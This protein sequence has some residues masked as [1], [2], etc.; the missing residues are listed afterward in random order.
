MVFQDPESLYGRLT[1]GDAG[2]IAEVGDLL[3]DAMRSIKASTSTIET[4]AGVAGSGWHG[5]AADAFA[6]RATRLGGV[7]TLAH[8]RLGVIAD[9]LTGAADAYRQLVD[10][11]DAAI[12][13]W[14]ASAPTDE[15]ARQQLAADVNRSMDRARADYEAKLTGVASA[16]GDG[17][18]DG[19]KIPHVGLGSPW[20]PQGMAY[21]KDKDQLLAAYYNGD[22]DL[23]EGESKSRLSMI[24]QTTGDEDKYVDL[25]GMTPDDAP[26]HVG[27][28]ATH[29]DNVWVTSSA[30]D[31]SYIY[32]YSASDLDAAANGESVPAR[33][34]LKVE[35]SSYATFADGRLWVGDF[36]EDKNEPGKLYSY[37]VNSCGSLPYDVDENGT[38]IV[39]PDPSPVE[40]PGQ[41]QGVVVRPDEIIYSQSWGRKND[42]HLLTQNRE[43]GEIVNSYELPN[44]SQGIVEVDGQIIT[45]YESGA[46]KYLPPAILS[47]FGAA[48]LGAALALFDPRD[49]MTRT[50]LDDLGAGGDGYETDAESLRSAAGSFDDATDALTGAANIV[51][52]VQLVPHLLGDVPAAVEFSTTITRLVTDVGTDLREGV[53]V[54]AA[55]ADGLL[56][57]A[58]SYTGLEDTLRRGFSGL[59]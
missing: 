19:P 46:G 50:D 56:A 31:D 57:T 8:R 23:E 35:A 5:K 32:R 37:P 27:G 13:R 29:G 10:A 7:T 55:T 53:E 26:N 45:Q 16:V 48:G 12:R 14:R 41:V 44:M 15:A 36:T 25:R 59:L 58:K 4:G 11:A 52:G 43:N 21:R 3:R 18:V 33:E 6:A 28:V 40:T 34:V 51:A 47:V 42:S 24:N 17:T 30:G 38:K 54:V 49:E 20:I 9:A 1:S 39:R 22:D 2:R